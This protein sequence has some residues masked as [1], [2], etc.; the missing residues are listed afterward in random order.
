MAEDTKKPAS[1]P[2][3]TQATGR[4]GVGDAVKARYKNGKKLFPGKIS[5]VH[6][7]DTYDVTYDDGDVEMRVR[8]D[9]IEGFEAAKPDGG[10]FQVGDRVKRARKGK[11]LAAVIHRVRRDGTFDI[12]YENG[13]LELE[14]EADMLEH[15]SAKQSSAVKP[16]RLEVG[17]KVRARYKGGAKF[18]N[19]EIVLAR[20]DGSFDIKYEDGDSEKHVEADCIE[21]V[22]V[23]AAAAIPAFELGQSVQAYYN[24]GLKLFVGKIARVHSDGTYD[25][26]YSDGD[27]ESRIPASRIV[28]GQA[29]KQE[30]RLD[31]GDKVKARYKGGDKFFPG[32]ISRVNMN[33]TFD[34]KYDDGDLELRVDASNVVALEA[35]SDKRM[36]EERTESPRRLEVGDA[37]NARFKGGTK[38]FSA[39]ITRVRSDGMYDVRYEDGDVE[40]GVSASLI[41][42]QEITKGS[43][44]KADK[45]DTK[46]KEYEVG[47]KVRARYQKG[48]RWFPGKI[49]KVRSDGT[50]DVR[51][52]DGDEELRVSR[53]LIELVKDDT[54]G[55]AKPTKDDD[56]DLF[57][58][59][60]SGDDTRSGKSKKALAILKKGDAVEADFKRKG[61]F[62]RGK[63]VKVHGNGSCDIEYD[64]GASEKRVDRQLIRKLS[65]GSNSAS[66]G[67]SK[68]ASKQRPSERAGAKDSSSRSDDVDRQQ[69][70]LSPKELTSDEE[71]PAQKFQPGMRVTYR[72]ATDNK[73][74][75]VGVVSRL[76]RDG[77]C[78]VKYEDG[79][80]VKRIAASILSVCSDSEDSGEEAASKQSTIRSLFRR[81]QSVISNWHRPNKFATPRKT[82]EWKKAVILAV[83]TDNTCTVRAIRILDI[84]RVPTRMWC[85][86]RWSDPL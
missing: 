38:K 61:K 4:F 11:R 14:V 19:G 48:S 41:E 49:L 40:T 17:T 30:K 8:A 25:I 57:G 36:K 33:G 82:S 71:Q 51:Y 60:G 59:D 69:K 76:H 37:V 84:W 68:S 20:T 42:L 58:D 62:H 65:S 13:E 9:L 78:D 50:F 3:K 1:P 86:R 83:H 44:S 75:R 47:A 34:I 80:T 28:A 31:V 22:D 10:A 85:V 12:K 26:K 43:L 35:E 53:D 39:K 18:F 72:K 67:D 6:R 45:S 77:S 7:D 15:E 64:A 21:V 23:P 55:K 24:G 74:R 54:A 5:K 81:H 46:T 52:D 66:E 32:K 79:E 56:D 29:K 73:S 27:S 63:I 70:P 16:K 2:K